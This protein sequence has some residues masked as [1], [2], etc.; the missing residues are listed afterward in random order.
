VR[1]FGDPVIEE[2]LPNLYRIE[3]PLPNSPLKSLNSFVI[4][5]SDRNLIID[6]GW[7]QKEC[8]DAMQAGLRALGVDLRKTDFF[9]THLHA[10]HLGLLSRLATETS[11]IYFNQP[12]ADRIESNISWDDFASIARLNGFPEMEL[13]TVSHSHPGFKYRSREQL[14]FHILKEG[15]TICIGEYIFKC[16]ET[17]GHT[18]GHMS[19]Y[20]PSKKIL[21]AGD[22]ILN[23]ITP[24]ISLWFDEWD[25]LKKY[26]E[27]LDKVYELDIELVLPGHRG[28]FRNCKERIQ[29]LKEHHQKRV[30]D[31]I[32]ILGKGTKNAFRVA[33]QMSWDIVYDSWDL[34]PVLQKWFATGE[35]IAHL[36]YLEG[37]REIR[38]EM[39]DQKI[40]YSLTIDP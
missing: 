26:L 19:L 28:I 5:D 29:E 24:S 34:F 2:I 7:D 10:D 11:T 17:P 8:M 35:A 3:I 20:E 12:D 40:V 33:S 4:K 31:I 37:K 32:S 27:S 39:R 23:D 21:I 9:I 22:H 15:H 13:Q 6:T 16:V 36:K 25:P 18:K 30:D 38:K 1:I 14:K